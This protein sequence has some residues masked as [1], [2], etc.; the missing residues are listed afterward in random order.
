[1][2]SLRDR[3]NGNVL[4]LMSQIVR[5]T[6][7]YH[8]SGQHHLE[9]IWEAGKPCVAVAWHGMTMMLVGFFAAHYDLSSFL[10]LMPDDWRGQALTVFVNRLGAQPFPMN[11]EGDASMA[12]ARSLAR[13]VRGVRQGK[14]CYITPDGPDGPAYVIKP[15][16]A[17]YARHGYRLNRWDTYTVP[18]PFAR[19]SVEIGAPI[20]IQDDADD[21]SPVL[22]TLTNR[23]HQVTAQATANY[24]E[25][26]A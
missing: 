10:L 5:R 23:L 1:M 14:N 12:T 11:L 19:V 22:Q 8:V 6:G 20:T 21:L 2:S 16:V 24:Y 13:L 26:R 4:Y 18:Y 3:V 15:G 25:Q 9:G 7:R 17:A